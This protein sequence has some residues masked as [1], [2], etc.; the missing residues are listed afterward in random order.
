MENNEPKI[1]VNKREDGTYSVILSTG[2][3]MILQPLP[4][5]FFLLHGELPVGLANQAIKAIK[6]GQST[7]DVEE[8]LKEF[9]A[10]PEKILS[11]LLFT[12]EAVKFACVNPKI[13]LTGE[14]ENEISALDLKEIE[15][16]EIRDLVLNG[17]LTEG[18]DRF[19]QRPGQN[20]RPRT[21]HKGD[22]YVT[23]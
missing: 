9:E 5:H 13:T 22:G 19:R 12:R 2:R 6:Q 14:G 21:N 23:V 7:D 18:L 16:I 15:F 1:T 10:D 4:T 3:E 17:G 8:K 11:K 20:A